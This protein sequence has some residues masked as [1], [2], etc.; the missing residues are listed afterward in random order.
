M[1]SGA[2]DYR[3]QAECAKRMVDSARDVEIKRQWLA[4][5]RSFR[6]LAESVERPARR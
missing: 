2:D 5:E 3:E 4:V 1:L 6:V